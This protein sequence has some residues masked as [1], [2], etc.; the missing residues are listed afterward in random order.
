MNIDITFH[1]S[2]G[3]CC[4]RFERRMSGRFS[5]TFTFHHQHASIDS[6]VSIRHTV[7]CFPIFS[8]CN[9]AHCMGKYFQIYGHKKRSI[10]EIQRTHHSSWF[11]CVVHQILGFFL[12]CLTFSDARRTRHQYRFPKIYTLKKRFSH[13][14]IRSHRHRTLFAASSIKMFSSISMD[15]CIKCRINKNTM[16]SLFC[17]RNIKC[18]IC[19]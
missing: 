5:C 13:I 12:F 15:V 8:L 7:V 2:S 17:T 18:N 14:L 10:D 19:F 3:V 4:T 9:R 11:N 1:F 16:Y 6:K